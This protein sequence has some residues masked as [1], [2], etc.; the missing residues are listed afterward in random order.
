[1]WPVWRN[2]SRRTRV[3][4]VAALVAILGCWRAAPVVDSAVD[5]E[6]EQLCG[7]TAGRL[8]AGPPAPLELVRQVVGDGDLQAVAH[9]GLRGV[10][11]SLSMTARRPARPT[12]SHS[13]L[14]Q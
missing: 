12:D 4:D 3:R 11:L 9:H 5:G 7:D 6:D 8:T 14:T 2:E 13:R 1:V 10:G